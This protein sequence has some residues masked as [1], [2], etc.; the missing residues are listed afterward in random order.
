M[1]VSASAQAAGRVT[2][3]YLHQVKCGEPAGSLSKSPRQF[4]P[5]GPAGCAGRR[6]RSGHGHSAL[7]VGL[8]HQRALP[9]PGGAG[10]L[11]AERGRH[12]TLRA[13]SG[14]NRPGGHAPTGIDPPAHRAAGRPPWHTEHR[15]RPR[16]RAALRLSG[17]CR[18]S[19]CRRAR[20]GRNRAARRGGG[21]PRRP[22]R[23][24][25][26]GY[27]ER[28]AARTDRRFRSARAVAVPAGDRGRLEHP[29]RYVLRPPV[30][31]EA[32]EWT[33]DGKVL[34]RLRRLWRDGTRAIR[35]EPSELL[36]KLAAVIPR[37]G[38][39]GGRLNE[40]LVAWLGAAAR[41]AITTPT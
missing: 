9:Q 27:R 19:G 24:G 29:A 12:A 35:F 40:G 13:R 1:R 3:K 4:P 18:D 8:E 37:P 20:S 17:V 25:A 6:R 5:V 26:G 7:R 16:R 32:L 38:E 39:P 30:A 10:D 33:P 14:A 11:R 41:T 36:E 15:G 28:P 22:R 21:R 23:S 31:R 2:D 34:L